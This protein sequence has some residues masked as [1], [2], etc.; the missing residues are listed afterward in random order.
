[1]VSTQSILSTSGGGSGDG[2]SSSSDSNRGIIPPFL[3]YGNNLFFLPLEPNFW[4]I[5]HTATITF[6][7]KPF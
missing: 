3:D 6:S 4:C 2:F 1:M 5:P 7:L